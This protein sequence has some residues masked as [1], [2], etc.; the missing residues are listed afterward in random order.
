MTT[1]IDLLSVL[2]TLRPQAE[3]CQAPAPAWWGRAA[4]SL[5]L[6][7]VR[8]ADP[9]L[10]EA[11]HEDDSAPRPFTTSTLMGHFP[12]KD[13]WPY[14]D[15]AQTY[16][17]RLTALR[18]DLAALLLENMQNGK[19]RTGGML[20]VDR[21][22]FTVEKVDAGQDAPQHP[23]AGAESYQE[24]S[25]AYL[26]AR[27]TPPKRI[28][29]VFASPTTFKSGGK[30]IPLPL[31][32]LVFGSLLERWN[33]TAPV[34]FPPEARRYASECMAIGHYKLSSRIVSLKS[35][36]MRV[37]AVG[38]ATYTCLTYDRY[39]MSVVSVLAAFARYAGVGAATAM[40]LGQCRQVFH[41]KE[42]S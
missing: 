40:G 34:T 11:L 9:S 33:T 10:A 19:L 1:P 13:G 41:N 28:S 14:L 32:E 18:L 29:L 20:E 30:H 5:L 12:R 8:S 2:I 39:W 4:H 7:L 31:P 25:A 36:G 21:L 15:P 6:N 42:E 38:E 3:A 35:G 16:T 26:L 23:W 37:G 22:P 17:L 27:T 24:L